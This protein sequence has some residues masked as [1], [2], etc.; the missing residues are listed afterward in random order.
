[1]IEII[2]GVLGVL[3]GIVGLANGVAGGW[4]FVIIGA[5]VLITQGFRYLKR[6]NKSNIVQSNKQRSSRKKSIRSNKD[7]KSMHSDKSIFQSKPEDALF[8]DEKSTNGKTN[9]AETSITN[10]AATIAQKEHVDSSAGETGTDRKTDGSNQKD[11]TES[12]DIHTDIPV[13]SSKNLFGF[14]V[15]EKDIQ[16][17][18]S[19]KLDTITVKEHPDKTWLILE[20]EGNVNLVNA[21]GKLIQ[22]LKNYRKDIVIESVHINEIHDMYEPRIDEHLTLKEFQ[23]AVKENKT[24]W[25][26][27]MGG[28]GDGYPISDLTSAWFPAR[29]DFSVD[30]IEATVHLGDGRVSIEYSYRK[31]ASQHKKLSD[32]DIGVRLIFASI[33]DTTK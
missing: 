31:K 14:R 22:T 28:S 26:Y 33:M 8:V 9:N 10:T 29:V 4:L 32:D 30:D 12:K 3:I 15:S 11:N 20:Y 13:G 23:V 17:V 1:M 7:I 18:Y 2:I 5:I 19:A 21:I 25:Q 24:L 6:T 27:G 16:Q